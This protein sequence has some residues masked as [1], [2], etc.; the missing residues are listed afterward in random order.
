MRISDEIIDK[1]KEIVS[2]TEAYL[3]DKQLERLKLSIIENFPE[4]SFDEDK[5]EDYTMKGK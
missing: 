3:D 5:V 4:I 2:E 1:I